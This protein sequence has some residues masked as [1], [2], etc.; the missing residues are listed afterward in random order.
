FL[1]II[2]ARR[3]ALISITILVLVVCVL[4]RPQNNGEMDSPF[5]GGIGMEIIRTNLELR[6][7]EGKWYYNGRPFEGFAVQFHENGNL[8]EK[9]A[10]VNGKKQG[11]ALK[12][13]ADGT[14]ASEKNYFMN[15]LEG[16]SMMWWPNGNKSNESFYLNRQ[17]HGV[18]TKWYPDGSKASVM[19]F[20]EGKEEGLQ[21]A[22]LPTGK[23]YVNYEAKNGRF[24]GLKRSNLCYQ[25]KDEVVQR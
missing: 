19:R 11:K 3:I 13:Y 7:K 22:W 20:R 17:R 4:L 21:Q 12:W 5:D 10:Y 16:K 14:L 18:Q 1:E 8:K 23:L 2:K 25:L 15:R 6:P 9:V 24:F